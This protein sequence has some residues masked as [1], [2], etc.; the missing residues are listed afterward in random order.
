[1]STEIAGARVCDA[2]SVELKLDCVRILVIL[3]CLMTAHY[4]FT[5]AQR[6]SVSPE[7]SGVRF[8]EAV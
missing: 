1:M 8:S 2:C 7:A 6:L 5:S 4:T 3:L